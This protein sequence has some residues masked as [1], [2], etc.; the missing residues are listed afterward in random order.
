MLQRP[1]VELDDLQ[2]RHLYSHPLVSVM[3][4]E[5]HHGYPAELLRAVL[6][7]RECLD[8][9]GYPRG[10]AGDGIG[11]WGRILGL[12]T[13]VATLAGTGAARLSVV[14]RMNRHRYDVQLVTVIQQAI[15]GL[16]GAAPVD[17]PDPL[18]SLR[19]V[20]RLLSAWPAEPPP[21]LS[22]DRQAACRWLQQQC[23]QTLGVLAD[24]GVAH[25]AL[26]RLEAEA[27]DGD[28][29]AE[30]GLIAHEAA[31][32][33]RVVVRQ[34]R[35]HIRDSEAALPP[36]LLDWL[37]DADR[38]CAGLLSDADARADEALVAA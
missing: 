35:R 10:L 11:R 29:R 32:Q 24:T 5:R 28:A 19:E 30:L 38:L 3:V 37:A 23:A 17:G 14:L 26:A 4:L 18:A 21:E 6:E 31:W 34:A 25:D 16:G 15:A 33:L 20:E 7:H 2:R 8:G 36:W 1:L 13:L 27:M 22:P 9:S 12:S